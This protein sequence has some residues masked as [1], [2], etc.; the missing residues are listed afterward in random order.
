MGNA[1]QHDVLG[2][3]LLPAQQNDRPPSTRLHHHCSVHTHNCGG[4]ARYYDNAKIASLL[5]QDMQ[6]LSERGWCLSCACPELVA[7]TNFMRKRK[8]LNN[9]NSNRPNITMV[10]L[11]GQ[12]GDANTTHTNNHIF[13]HNAKLARRHGYRAKKVTS[14]P[15]GITR[16]YHRNNP[17]YWKIPAVL[18][19]CQDSRTDLVWFIDGDMVIV[20]PTF[21]I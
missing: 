4:K 7:A 12:W 1:A 16:P 10:Q 5:K 18:E 19:A 15:R 14:A 17:A 6:K 20:D 2:F 11:V 3:E 21:R 8:R 9:D 13:E